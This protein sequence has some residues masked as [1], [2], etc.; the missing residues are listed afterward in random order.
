MF[1]RGTIAPMDKHLYM[2]PRRGARFWF[3]MAFIAIAAITGATLLWIV[4]RGVDMGYWQIAIGSVFTL[5]LIGLVGLLFDPDYRAAQQSDD[6]LTLAN[7]TLE[8][9]RYGMTKEA[10]QELCE[11]LLPS[12]PA[13]A[14]GIT[15]SEVVMGYAGYGESGSLQGDPIRTAAIRDVLADGQPRTLLSNDEIGAP[16]TSVRVNAAIIQPLYVGRKIKGTLMF[17]YRRPRQIGQVQKSI[18][19]GMSRLLSTQLSAVA[20]EEQTKLATSME[21]KMLQAQINPHFLFNTINT[22]ASFIRTD[23]NQARDLL[24]EFAVFY[25]STLE[26]ANDLIPLEREIKQ[27]ERYFMFERARFGDERLCLQID[28]QPEVG[29]MMVPSF[30]IQPLVENSVRH[31]MK[32]E[33]KLTISVN[34]RMTEE[35]AVIEVVDDGAGMSP[36]KLRT[37]MDPESSQGLGIAVRNVHD[38]MESYFGTGS[39]MDIDS[40]LDQGTRVTFTLMQGSVGDFV[41]TEGA[42]ELVL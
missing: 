1:C 11:L 13:I 20:L 23:P 7:K 16:L 21:L 2:S 38:R 5:S 41:P 22:I 9:L 30:M 29:K 3:E 33:G 4:V 25:R 39:R 19:Q 36:E 37:M 6:V 34:G 17:C 40:K 15:N 12:I 26:D 32:S 8:C 42:Q 10:A 14:V 35:G 18:A 28:I 24:R 31:A 27:V